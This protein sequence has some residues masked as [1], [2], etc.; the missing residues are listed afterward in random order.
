MHGSGSEQAMA[1]RISPGQ[2]A[3][4]IGVGRAAVY[5][6]IRRGRLPAVKVAGRILIDPETATK[7]LIRP[8]GQGAGNGH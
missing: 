2:L 6:L 1:G 4:S 7:A 5:A 8:I 3:A